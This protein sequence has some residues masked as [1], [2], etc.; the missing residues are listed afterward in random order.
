MQLTR[1]RI[2]G[3]IGPFIEFNPDDI[4]VHHEHY[5]EILRD[6]PEQSYQILQRFVNPALD[7]Y[8]RKRAVELRNN[9][10]QEGTFGSTD[11]YVNIMDVQKK[12]GYFVDVNILAV[13]RF[14]SLLSCYEREQYFKEVGLPPR[15]VTMVNHDRAY[16]NL[17][18]TVHLV[19]QKK[20]ADRIRV[21]KRGYIM[22]RPELVYISGD[23]KYSNVAECIVTERMNNR[24]QI[25]SIPEEYLERIGALKQKAG[26]DDI[27]MRKLEELET[28]F[29]NE[30]GKNVNHIR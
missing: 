1:L 22:E 30:M 13:D 28:Q 25:L 29:V 6:F 24:R 9:I 8:L 2:C 15:T 3:Q 26:D 4:A 12:G 19:E 16:K 14:E 11:A 17:L 20:L 21:F 18:D 27:Q 10:V 5:K 23:R 7:N